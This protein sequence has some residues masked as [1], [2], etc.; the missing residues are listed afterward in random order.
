MAARRKPGARPYTIV[1]R[2]PR[3]NRRMN[4]KSP[5]RPSR[6]VARATVAPPAKREA[7][8][9]QAW[10]DAAKRALI[11]EGTAGVEVNKLAK[12]LGWSRGGFYWFFVN[13]QQ[14]LDELAEYW[15]QTSL[16]PF[17]K[18][19]Q[20][21]GSNGTDEYLAVVEMWVGESDYDPKWDGAVRDWARTSEDVRKK[22]AAVDRRRI[23]ILEQ[24]FNDMGYE[25]KEAHIR[26]RIMYYHQVGYYALG[27]QESRRER[28]E[29][30]PYYQK[31]LTGRSR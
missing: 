8:G 30:L 16:E 3:Y 28:R 2:M 25:G 19:L 11:E 4:S 6:Q 27:I 12:R 26:A 9:R 5:K 7:L 21:S 18:I 10:L 20:A 24:I 1:W 13:R 23:A 31:V 29:L 14:L 17:E 22:V 15:A